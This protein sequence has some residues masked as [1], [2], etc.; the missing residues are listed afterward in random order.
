MEYLLVVNLWWYFYYSNM[1]LPV[2][3]PTSFLDYTSASRLLCE[4]LC[5][6]GYGDAERLFSLVIKQKPVTDSIVVHL[7]QCPSIRLRFLLVAV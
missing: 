7:Q 4:A 2:R 6:K 1:V 3:P 5:T